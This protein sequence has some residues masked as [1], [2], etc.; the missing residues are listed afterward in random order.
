M[1]PPDAGPA[2][3]RT[4]PGPATP[5]GPSLLGLL[6]RLAHVLLPRNRFGDGLL[7]ILTFVYRHRR[8]PRWRR[9]VTFNDHLFAMK[10]RGEL[11][12]PL[13]QYVSDKLL[14][15]DYISAR[16]GAEPVLETLAVLESDAEIEAFR[17]PQMACVV[18]PTHLSGHYFKL[19]PGQAPDRERMKRW[20]R[21][22]HYDIWREANYRYLR[23]RILVEAFFASE[24]EG[25]THD[26]K[27]F[28]ARGRVK[29]IQSVRDRF[30]E[31]NRLCYSPRWEKMPFNLTR[32]PE[33]EHPRPPRL[34][35]MIAAAER[36]SAAFP[37]IRVD[38]LVAGERFKIGELTNLHM[39][40]HCRVLPP[41]FEYR[42]G[43]LFAEPD[44]KVEDVL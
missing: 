32:P 5:K 28:C 31:M 21:L 23:P 24:P 17:P 14:V 4:S 7:S 39:N 43:R 38:F 2:E 6:R 33:G 37:I 11:Y 18:K 34:E 3:A 9:P 25:V 29:F 16:V 13:R 35:E 19:T 26:C 22:N 1:T 41:D 30:G 44:L 36:V 8:L 15:K 40:A 42:L 10:W 12:D 27:F 20:L